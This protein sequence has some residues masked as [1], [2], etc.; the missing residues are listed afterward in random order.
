MA[1]ANAH[2]EVVRLLSQL[3]AHVLANE[4]RVPDKFDE[5]TTIIETITRVY[6][7]PEPKEPDWAK[8]LTPKEFEIVALLARRKGFVH[9]EAIMNA[10]YANRTEPPDEKIVPVHISKIRRKWKRLNT[11]YWIRVSYGRGYQLLRG[12]AGEEYP[13]AM[14][15]AEAA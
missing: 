4:G 2:Q 11:P 12:R 15:L 7:E 6:M 14:V 8:G 9:R 5:A 1:T 13:T 10:L 3:K